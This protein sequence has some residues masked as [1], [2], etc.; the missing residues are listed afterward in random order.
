MKL[1]ILILS[2]YCFNVETLWL[3]PIMFW[4]GISCCDF[5]FCRL[6]I[7]G[8]IKSLNSRVMGVGTLVF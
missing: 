7:S 1:L 6:T 2:V 4:G 3:F 8:A 5:A